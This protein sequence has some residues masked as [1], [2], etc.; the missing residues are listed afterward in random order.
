M[1]FR[2]IVLFF[3]LVLSLHSVFATHIIGGEMTYTH[4]SGNTYNI[5]LSVYRDDFNGNPQALFDS[6]AYIALYDQ[7]GNFV[8]YYEEYIDVQ[9]N[10]VDPPISNPCL[11]QP[12]NV[13][14]QKAIYTFNITVPNANMGYHVVYARCCRNGALI[15]NLLDPDIEGGT[16]TA[17]IPPTSTY[18][19]S[20]PLFVQDRPPI[21]ICLNKPI[22]FDHSATDADGDSLYYSFCSPIKG[23]DQNGPAIDQGSSPPSAQ[24]FTPAF[25][26]PPFVNVNYSA[27]YS[28]SNPFPSGSIANIDPNT[29]YLY[30]NAS[31]YG[32]YVVGVCVEEYRNGVFLGRV[33]RDFQYIV[34]DCDIP[35][36]DIPTYGSV[37]ETD[38]GV[39]V[40]ENFLG[41]YQKNCENYTVTFDNN[42]VLPNGSQA[43]ASNATYYW[44]FGDGT[45]STAFE[46]T[47]TF[48]DTG[49]Y[50]VKVAITITD[51]SGGFCSDTGYFVVYTYPVLSPDF[52]ISN[53]VGPCESQTVN[54]QEISG[55]ATYDFTNEWS[56]DFGDGSPNATIQNPSHAYPSAGTYTV[57]LFVRT[58]KGC[59]KEYEEDVTIHPN[60][61][62]AFTA[63]AP[64]CL[65]QMVLFTN[66]SNVNNGSITNYN[67]D[68]DDGN[69]SNLNN[70][71][72][73]FLNA[74]NYNVMLFARS[75]NG[76]YDT[77]YQNVTINP[78]PVTNTSANSPICPNTS[79][80]LSASGG[81]TYVW[82]PDSL[83]NN[84][85]ISNPT[86][87]LDTNAVMFYVQVTD[88]NG[89][90][91]NDS[92][93]VDL[94]PLPQAEA[95][96]DT[97]VCLNAANVISFNTTVQLQAS[98][99]IAYTWTPSTGLNN[100]NVSNP[101]A[102]PTTTTTYTVEVTDNN[103][104]TA[105]DSVKVTVLNPALELIE[106]DIDSVC[107][108]D[109]VYVEV[110]DLGNVTSYVWTPTSF[111]TDPSVREPGFYPP[112]TRDYYLSTINYCYLDRDTITI[113]VISPPPVD[114]GPLDSICYG[115]DPYQLDAHPDSLDV[116]LWTTT[117]A[118]ITDVN[119]RN[120]FI[121]PLVDTWYYI[122]AEEF[123]G[124]LVCRS[125]DSVQILAYDT[126]RLALSYPLD[127]VG[128]ICLGDSLE[129]K[130]TTNDGIYFNWTSNN[131]TTILNANSS[132]ATVIPIDSTMFYH[133]T[134]NIHACSTS[135]SIFVNVQ[136]PVTASVSGDSIMCYG[137]FANLQGNGGLYYHW[138]PDEEDLFSNSTY[139][140]TQA[141]PDSTITVFVDVANDCF[142][143]TAYHTITVYQ[144]PNVD[145]GGDITIYRDET[146]FL[147]GN[148]SGS[149]V[150]Y[151][152]DR[153][154]D[155][156]VS[157]PYTYNPEM[158]PFNTTDYI[159]EITDDFTGCKN[160]DT[161]RVNVDV[162]TLLAFPTGFSPNGD[163][164]NDIAKI[165]KYLN[166]EKLIDFT[167][168]DRWGEIVFITEDISKGWDGTYKGKDVEIGMYAWII[169]AQTKDN[170]KITKTGN[171]TIIR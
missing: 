81:T 77:I 147:S 125:E 26:G 122:Y 143:D 9:N 8:T 165:I 19:N 95:G 117:D 132:M 16:Y 29:G 105:Q 160:Y 137:F 48:P 155:G 79:V 109:T 128:Y 45:T 82:T 166:I 159:L 78:L 131:G 102:S 33:L 93:F 91:N 167:I 152:V 161:A 36:A 104:C 22:T 168:Y 31:A 116:Y 43:N 2:K 99:G 135:D 136:L 127:Y 17:F 63:N 140:S 56:W 89:C 38:L 3:L 163:G 11:N 130:S 92:V 62:A 30:V 112:S 150:W 153:T 149:P 88:A 1:N 40:P 67:W 46:P 141:Y 34:V 52:S 66:N 80:Q 44:D 119:I 171:I 157:S 114:A 146:G 64:L 7:N 118:S 12:N 90:I 18:Q 13:R 111:V 83:L 84:A 5:T 148:G 103:S 74:G 113:D 133:T 123:I 27:G 107:S 98:G 85:N 23:L 37:P 65:G 55:T 59:T 24:G 35:V 151:T 154:I 6:P 97:S 126:P 58:D 68:F 86:A 142:N 158:S 54:F 20:S 15:N 72:H 110:L 106:V 50:V 39:D 57:T 162:L 139:S 49:A 108:G 124:S 145:A 4:V 144:L 41:I 73:T 134:T 25:Y 71:S 87:S 170:E 129:L 53:T 94:F 138:Y 101:N 47:H 51:Q 42:S 21:Y 120:P 61:N 70:P 164:V 121:S 115:D 28:G 32:A 75:D 96:E 14:I 60:P 76:C 156:I 10:N 69:T 100:P 169:N